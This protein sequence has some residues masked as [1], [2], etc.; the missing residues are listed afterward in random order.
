MPRIFDIEFQYRPIGQGLF[1]TGEITHTNSDQRFTMVYDCGVKYNY[2]VNYISNE[3]TDFAR[4]INRENNLDVL[5]IS[6]F[7]D[8]HISRIPELLNATRGCKEVFLPYLHPDQMLLYMIRN[9]G[10]EDPVIDPNFFLDPAGFLKDLKAKNI[11]FIHPSNEGET[12]SDE[13]D[14][15]SPSEIDRSEKY[16]FTIEV[17]LDDMETLPD[18][19][20]VGDN[21]HHK[22]DRGQVIINRIWEFKFFNRTVNTPVTDTFKADLDN[23]LDKDNASLSDVRDYFNTDPETARDELHALY[24]RHFNDINQTSLA[25][26]HGAVSPIAYDRIRSWILGRPYFPRHYQVNGSSHKR[27]ANLL[28]GDL[29]I[30]ND[31][32]DEI[33]NHWSTLTRQRVKYAQVPHHGAANDMHLRMFATFPEADN[34]IV[35]YGLGNQFKH[36]KANIVD[37]IVQRRNHV[38]FSNNQIEHVKIRYKIENLPPRRI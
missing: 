8:D 24:R 31:C 10:G 9:L 12:D 28:V 7:D 18:D 38:L 4:R 27:R 26:Y 13:L 14:P 19:A 25:V 37:Q 6:H 35:N 20:I 15:K 30:N 32:L 16:Q 34:Y 36:P 23:L 33:E 11:T 5:I 21:I 29:K 17:N 22:K 2:A 1:Y 3:I